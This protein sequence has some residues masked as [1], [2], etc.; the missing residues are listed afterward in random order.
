MAFSEYYGYPIH[1]LRKTFH[2]SVQHNDN[3]L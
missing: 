2:L 1:Q 3:D